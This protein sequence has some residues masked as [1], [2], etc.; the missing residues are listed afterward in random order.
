[1][2]SHKEDS[3]FDTKLI[4]AG[5]D[6]AAAPA[7]AVRKLGE[8]R[9]SGGADDAA[10]AKALGAIADVSAAAM[11]A[12]MERSAS[13]A[14]RREVRRA[15]FRLHQRGIEAPPSGPA[16][17]HDQTAESFPTGISALMSPPDREGVRIVWLMHQR[18]GGKIGRIFAL[19]SR[20]EGLIAAE[21]SELTKRELKTQRERLEQNAGTKLVEV[22][23]RF[24][25]FILCDAYRR[26]PESRRGRVG[27]FL[28][29]RAELIP[30]APPSEF[31]HPVY[32]DL[33]A[34][35][36]QGTSP[37]LLKEPEFLE[38][39]LPESL[40]KKYADEIQGAQES[41]I[42]VSPIQQRER[43]NEAIER[44]L[45]SLLSGES[46]EQIRRSLEDL[47]YFMARAG[48]RK[49]AG[50]AVAAAA[51]VRDHAE[52]KRDAFFQDWIRMQLGAVVA[53]EQQRA[54]EEPRLI[55]TPAE[56]MRAQQQRSRRR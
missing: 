32:E 12:D 15:L 36:A 38:W 51:K 42:V 25:D 30:T 40:V 28:L 7:D 11:L 56:A 35:A 23:G 53:E 14:L 17:V 52:V 13:G 18:M 9:S 33:A 31:K 44:A 2:A 6:P 3:N 34:E 50:W 4:A 29:L 24:A 43:V 49:Q 20:D 5:F 48:R 46:G 8:L 21:P 26:T 41:V 10:I 27:N 37:D 16:A 39:R 19:D 1:V 55:M 45:E 54:A 47:A 22:D